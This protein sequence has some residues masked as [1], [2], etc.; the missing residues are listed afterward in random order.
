MR[1][2][3]I[4]LAAG[5]LPLLQAEPLNYDYIYFSNADTETDAGKQDSGETAGGFWS[6]TD[7]MHLFGSYDTAGSYTGSGENPN[8]NYDTRTVR[9]GV[10]AHYL[11]GTRVMLAPSLSVLRAEREINAPG[12][13]A[14][15]EFSDTGF[16][17]QL[18]LRL[19]MNDWLELTAGTSSTR[20]FDETDTQFVGG[21]LFHATN[22]LAV[23][24]LYHEHDDSHSMEL[25]ARFYY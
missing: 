21:V 13:I 22:W 10:G 15:R 16:G 20:V 25:T 19:A 14:P 9:A 7:S 4:L 2:V 11:I 8:W 12:W 3:L 5:W 6:F 24:A 17:L 23:G 18:D 1:R